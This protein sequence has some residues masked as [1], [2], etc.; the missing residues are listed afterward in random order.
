MEQTINQEVMIP[1]IKCMTGTMVADYYGVPKS[2]IKNRYATHK[3]V[4][5]KFGVTTLNSREFEKL[6]PKNADY[7]KSANRCMVTFRFGN[8]MAVPVSTNKNWIFPQEA[9]EYMKSI[10]HPSTRGG[11]RHRKKNVEEHNDTATAIKNAA[12]NTEEKNLPKK[13]VFRNPEE[14]RL[15]IGLAKA[16]A[17]GDTM[18]V[19]NAALALDTYRIRVIDELRQE[20]NR[21]IEESDKRIMWTERRSVTKVVKILSETFGQKQTD[22]WNSIYCKLTINYHLPLES[23]EKFPLIDAV[24]LSEWFLVYRA[25]VEICEDKCIDTHKLFEKAEIN[26]AGLE[27]AIRGKL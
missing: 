17:S 16:Y 27:R 20:N 21:L 24:E 23:R 13:D 5:D 25:I 8:G 10:L 6:L 7:T 11:I 22:I 14:R 12:T 9:V 4:F 18:K 3:E 1:Y 19:L 2:L 15:C 26:T